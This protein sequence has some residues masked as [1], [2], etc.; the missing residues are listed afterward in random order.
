[1]ERNVRIFLGI[2]IGLCWAIA[3]LLIYAGPP[4]KTLRI[5]VRS[6][7]EFAEGNVDTIKSDAVRA[8]LEW[9]RDREIIRQ[10]EQWERWQSSREKQAASHDKAIQDEERRQLAREQHA[11]ALDGIARTEASKRAD[12][13]MQ[14]AVIQEQINRR[15]HEANG[16]PPIKKRKLK[17]DEADGIA[18]D[19]GLRQYLK[20]QHRQ[21]LR[22]KYARRAR[23]SL[24]AR[25]AAVAAYEVNAR[26]VANAHA[27]MQARAIRGW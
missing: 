4:A 15:L 9:L 6:R 13:E 16:G 14:A 8:E 17:R 22:Q 10:K 5:A 11:R 26:G 25:Y 7:P 2:S 1:M 19:D 12:E 18:A 24:A 23:K 27:A 21:E 20:E 3:G